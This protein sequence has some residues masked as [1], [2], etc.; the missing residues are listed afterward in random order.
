MV[1]FCAKEVP[2]LK[3]FVLFRFKTDEKQLKDHYH[4]IVLQAQFAAG[5]HFVWNITKYFYNPSYN[6]AIFHESSIIFPNSYCY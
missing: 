1:C 6:K 5:G 3:R 4:A 2:I